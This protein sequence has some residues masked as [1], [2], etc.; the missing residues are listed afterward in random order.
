MAKLYHKGVSSQL[1]KKGQRLA[2]SIASL[3]EQI[4]ATM[5]AHYAT[6][7]PKY[8]LLIEGRNAKARKLIKNMIRI[9]L[10]CKKR[11]QLALAFGM[12][13][14]GMIKAQS[15]ARQP[16]YA[17]IASCNMV[18]RWVSRQ[19]QRNYKKWLE[20]WKESV[21][22]L[23]FLERNQATAILQTLFRRWRDRRKFI[24]MHKLGPYNGILSDIALAPHR[25]NVKYTIPRVIRDER[26][27]YW[28]A[29]TLVQSLYRCWIE[30]KDYFEKKRRI[31]LLQSICRMWPKYRWFQRLKATTVRCQ[32]WMRRT[33]KHRRYKI[34]RKATIIVQKYVRRYQAIML[35]LRKL[36]EIWRGIEEQLV[37]AIRIQCR[38]RIRLARK[39]L[40]K[41]RFAVA[42]KEYAA[43]VIQ[44]NWYRCK[45]AFHTFFLMCALREREQQDIALEKLSTKMGR[46]YRARVIQR[47]YKERYNQRIISNVIKVQC[48][49]RGR[50]GY[51]LVDI[52]RKQR[53]ASRKLRHWVRARLRFRH[54]T[55]R[56]IQRWWWK[57][58]KLRLLKHLWYKHRIL[59]RDES[60]ALSEAKHTA[61]SRI[62]AH[63]KGTW[64]RRWVKR[65]CAALMI[66]K[67][68]RFL[69]GIKKWKH[70]KRGRINKS[71]KKIVDRMIERA[72]LRRTA[73]LVAKHS[74]MII[75][76]QALARGFIVRATMLRVRRYAVKLG[77][78]AVRVQRFWRQSGAMTKAVEEVM[79][80]K[81]M[82]NNPFKNCSCLHEILHVL[83]DQCNGFYSS[84]D[85]RVGMKMSS[86]L[87]RMGLGELEIFFPKKGYTFAT[88]GH[89]VTVEK[90]TEWYYAYH[91]KL[92]EK[93][94]ANKD[95]SA[96]VA[97]RVKPAPTPLFQVVVNV[98]KV[99]LYPRHGKQSDRLQQISAIP[100]HSTPME[101]FNA[102]KKMFLRRFGKNLQTRAVNFARDILEM[103]YPVFNNYQAYGASVLTLGQISRAMQIPQDSTLVLKALDEL[104]KQAPSQT[105]ERKWDL[106]R[107]RTCSAMLQLAFDRAISILPPCA[108]RSM[109]EKVVAR[110]ASYRRKVGFLL[111]KSKRAQALKLKA[112]AVKSIGKRKPGAAPAVVAQVVEIKRII[113]D[114]PVGDVAD[115]AITPLIPANR[116]DR[117][118]TPAETL[119][120]V[121]RGQDEDFELDFQASICKIYMTLAERLLMVTMGIQGLKNS[122]ANKAVR[123]AVAAERK[124]LFLESVTSKYLQE[125][126][127]NNVQAVWKKFKRIETSKKKLESIMQA[128][129][130]RRWTIEQVLSYILRHHI[131]T[132]YDENGYMYYVD[133]RGF[134]SYEMPVYSFKQFLAC[135]RIQSKARTFIEGARKRRLK[136]EEDERREIELAEQKLIAERRKALKAMEILVIPVME[137]VCQLKNNKPSVKLANELV[138]KH[139]NAHKKG[140]NGYKLIQSEDDLEREVAW[141]YRYNRNVEMRC[142][143][144]ALLHTSGSNVAH[145]SFNSQNNY[146]PSIFHSSSKGQ[147]DGY[148]VVVLFRIKPSEELC[149]VRTVKG[150]IIRGVTT[151]RIRHMN[152]DI[153][154][155][156]EARYKYRKLFYRGCVKHISMDTLRMMPV[157]KIQYE[158]SEVEDGLGRDAVRPTPDAV[159]S[160]L[161]GR[162]VQLNEVRLMVRRQGH[163]AN[164]AAHRKLVQVTALVDKLLQSGEASLSQAVEVDEKDIDNDVEEIFQDNGQDKDAQDGEQAKDGAVQEEKGVEVDKDAPEEA[165]ELTAVDINA[166]LQ[167]ETGRA[168]KSS[169]R[170]KV[171]KPKGPKKI[172]QVTVRFTKVHINVTKAPLLY[173]WSMVVL[174]GDDVS[175]A[176]NSTLAFSV[177][178]PAAIR[179]VNELTGDEVSIHE[180]PFYNA[181]EIHLIRKIQQRWM[182]F[183]AVKNIRQKALTLPIQQTIQDSIDKG[184]K[185]AFIGYKTEGITVMQTLARSGYG[186]IAQ[187]IQDHYHAL[188]KPLL[189][190]TL[191]G[192]LNFPKEEYEKLGI[193]QAQHVREM[194]E[195][196]TVFKKLSALDREKK[197]ALF[198]Y[199]S[200][201]Y[202]MR[203]I[204][205]CIQA[206][207]EAMMKKFTRAVK[208]GQTRTRQACQ[209]LVDQSMFPHSHLQIETYLRKYADKAELI[210]VRI[211]HC[212]MCCCS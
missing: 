175:L 186:D 205:E 8:V 165:G 176:S 123:R 198:N 94:K 86:F 149:D 51:N 109:M 69:N 113:P 82:E 162:T 18:A 181:R 30:C 126:Q 97:K 84:V 157:Y 207:I 2:T 195:F 5:Q 156:V 177:A 136:K 24:A 201:P 34:L 3:Q 40:R 171:V 80:R 32:A 121:F 128:V 15:A 68:W 81:R 16:Q 93:E 71:V 91:N 107:L 110:V 134:A 129:E 116:M 41:R 118:I 47:K 92:K 29:A 87:Y 183:K 57:L 154:T 148:D 152:Y 22:W 167:G 179:F 120:L 199:Y 62:Q 173:N 147:V 99:P 111:Q 192:I 160:F 45:N 200:D 17:R 48:W 23:M 64:D 193:I 1:E 76:P 194:K 197:L 95:N 75:K 212:M 20:K 155:D 63:V 137:E 124:R 114:A 39:R 85:P 153:N 144:W 108:A 83:R 131:C 127:E 106:E 206:S 125:Q 132:Y 208:A 36:D 117:R 58:K 6:F 72:V 67:N 101:A 74:E 135:E 130:L 98:L 178:D 185:L 25:Y 196:Q 79:A 59:D 151:K 210:R 203:S 119:D 7:H 9:F 141:K 146:E 138:N 4:H 163:F 50:L 28:V 139:Y 49:L 61:A 150:K 89:K 52:L 65:H 202:D 104:R 164:L 73:D 103:T 42:M 70:M 11:G 142:G 31:I 10:K 145:N 27:I 90:L 33:I 37:A 14:I 143:T 161:E 56:R 38:Y 102:I 169:L 180:P 170:A 55:A 12:L 188:R 190:L 66:Q 78:A 13:K 35:K 187:T 168:P 133:E 174:P 77:L 105:D 43:L 182:L 211:L 158:D 159:L 60:K 189:S 53:W 184:S 172:Q 26:R 204:Q 122:W 100:E 115:D 46:N 112:E 21:S 19:R 140:F 166:S 191:D 54:R 209:Q 44:R 96:S 88:D